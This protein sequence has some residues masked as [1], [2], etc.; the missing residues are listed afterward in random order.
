MLQEQHN[1]SVSSLRIVIAACR[2]FFGAVVL[3]HSSVSQKGSSTF[4][5]TDLVPA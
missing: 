3:Q 1:I 2:V 5:N 4:L